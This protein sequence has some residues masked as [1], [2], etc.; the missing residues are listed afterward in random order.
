[1][2]TKTKQRK[3]GIRAWMITYKNKSK[4]V[5]FFNPI[6]N[7]ESFYKFIEAKVE[8]VLITPLNNKPR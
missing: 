2:P 3:K 1:M 5:M 8:R 4:S 6:K 7:V